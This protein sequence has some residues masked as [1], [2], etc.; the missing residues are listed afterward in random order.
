[1]PQD[2]AEAIKW[3]TLGANQGD[4]FAQYGLGLMFRNGYGVE[5]DVVEAY[6]WLYLAAQQ[7]HGKAADD[8][9][10]TAARMTAEQIQQ[11]KARA[12]AWSPS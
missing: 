10:A 1:V 12:A 4:A 3:Y 6:K 2:D 8:L 5:P 9:D 11:A 7:G